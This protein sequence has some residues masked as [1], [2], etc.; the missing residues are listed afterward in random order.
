LVV[1][2]IGATVASSACGPAANEPPPETAK[3]ALPSDK[4]EVTMERSD[5]DPNAGVVATAPS[6]VTAPAPAPASTGSANDPSED[7]MIGGPQPD[8]A[9]EKAVAPVRPRLRACYK[10]ALAAEPGIGGNATFD[11]T[12]GKDGHVASARFVKRDGLNE[13]MVGCLLAA[14][15]A[16]TFEPTRKSQIVAFS[17]GTPPPPAT[18]ST[19]DAGAPK[20]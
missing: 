13:D 11:A 18:P 7:P 5:V 10:K 16:M 4:T 12:I 9:V 15:K 3:K 20:K 14:V 1:V 17:F 6:G 8:A 2:A 19:A